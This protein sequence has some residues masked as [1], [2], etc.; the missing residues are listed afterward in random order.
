MGREACDDAG[1][2]RGGD[3]EA[4]TG[5]NAFYFNPPEV[6]RLAL[7][8]V[9][10]ALRQEIDRRIIA[11]GLD[12][13]FV[14]DHAARRFILNLEAK[15]L[16]RRTEERAV[17][18]SVPDRWIDHLRVDLAAWVARRFA[19]RPWA[20]R[21]SGRIGEGARMREVSQSV[22]VHRICPHIDVA[23]EDR[24]FV[25]LEWLKEEPR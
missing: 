1:P 18:A 8:R 14:A 9:R 13:S 4:T 2:G 10:Y 3:G 6:E 11:Q 19:G 5:W 17:L 23:Y 21:L 7:E 12:V 24:P 15:F 25:H 20:K 22:V 16:G